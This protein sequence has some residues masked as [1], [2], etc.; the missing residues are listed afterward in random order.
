MSKLDEQTHLIIARR[1]VGLRQEELADAVNSHLRAIKS[2]RSMT[3]NT[4][5]KL[6]TGW[7]KTLR[8]D[9]ALAYTTVLKIT[10]N[11]LEQGGIRVKE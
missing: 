8:Q 3:W 2:I 5:C 7:K 6:E 10:T 9:E 4:I 1:K 11:E